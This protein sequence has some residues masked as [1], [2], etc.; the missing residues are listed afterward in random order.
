MKSA[1]NYPIDFELYLFC[2]TASQRADK[3]SVYARASG[4]KKPGG[5]RAK[6]SYKGQVRDAQERPAEAYASVQ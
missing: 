5:E 1:Q 6:N 3:R 2:T 4:E